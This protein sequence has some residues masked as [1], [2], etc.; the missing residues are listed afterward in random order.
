[1]RK[2]G[3]R[4]GHWEAATLTIQID[5]LYVKQL[6]ESKSDA[7]KVYTFLV[8]AII[9][10]EGAHGAADQSGPPYSQRREV[11]NEFEVAAFGG[12]LDNYNETVIVM[13]NRNI[14]SGKPKR[15]EKTERGW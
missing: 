8:Q 10:H 7:L 3:K 4:L 13:N 6:E 1:M 5:P 14:E 11:G 12:T 2:T 15:Y 9:L